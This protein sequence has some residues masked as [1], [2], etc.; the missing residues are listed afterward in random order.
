MDFH[1]TLLVQYGTSINIL[2]IPKLQLDSGKSII[3]TSWLTL[4]SSFHFQFQLL[5]LKNSYNII[6]FAGLL[7]SLDEIMYV[8]YP[9]KGIGKEDLLTIL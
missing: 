5:H 7:M 1:L 9:A 8:K 2:P 3:F 4:Y 6:S